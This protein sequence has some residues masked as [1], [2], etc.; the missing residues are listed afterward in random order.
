M[1]LGHGIYS[2]RVNLMSLHMLR[3]CRCSGNN[4]A[5]DPFWFDVLMIHKALRWCLTFGVLMRIFFPFDDPLMTLMQ[6]NEDEPW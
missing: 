6:N 1:D 3:T 5:N 4:D 2:L